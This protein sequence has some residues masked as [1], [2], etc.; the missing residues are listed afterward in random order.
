M[1]L[2]RS[3]AGAYAALPFWAY[4]VAAAVVTVLVPLIADLLHGGM[5]SLMTH[6]G[7]R[8]PEHMV[9]LLLTPKNVEPP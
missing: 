3:P 2:F 9:G 8:P 4:G 1:S 5:R 6:I 7:A